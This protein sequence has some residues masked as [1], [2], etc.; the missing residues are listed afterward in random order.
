MASEAVVQI[1]CA[2]VPE[3]TQPQ[4]TEGAS[5]K[6][7]HLIRHGQGTHNL[8]AMSFPKGRLCMCTRGLPGCPYLNDE[9][10]DAHLTLRGRR[11]ATAAGPRLLQ[12]ASPPEVVFVSP[13]SRTLQTATIA[14][15]KCPNL[16]VPVIA[17]ELTRERNG[18]HPCDK[19]SAREH[20]EATYPTVD[21]SN[22]EYGPDPLWTLKR[23][24]EDE[25]AARG[26]RFFLSLK[27]RPETTFAVFSHSSF[28][29][30]TI[31][32]SFVSDD[33][34]VTRRFETGES[35]AVVL[36]YK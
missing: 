1:H 22:I 20:V 11:Q 23:E 33:P 13:L 28:L 10:F 7:V 16:R 34:N 17:E 36:T 14:L 31:T 30:N 24:T 9:H 5:Q 2:L 12:T 32:R 6:V 35:R 4:L 3:G 15:S 19:R 29:Y 27:D 25:L 26:K 18:V 8:F 21:F